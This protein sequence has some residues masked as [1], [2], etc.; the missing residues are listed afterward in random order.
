VEWVIVI[1]SS[2]APRPLLRGTAL[3]IAGAVHGH[4]YEYLIIPH[5]D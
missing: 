4:G 5:A 3:R 1:E 2:E